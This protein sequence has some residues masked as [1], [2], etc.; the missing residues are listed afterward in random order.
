MQLGKLSLENGNKGRNKRKSSP[1]TVVRVSIEEV[2]D[3]Y[4]YIES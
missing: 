1:L 2:Q 3:A 4:V